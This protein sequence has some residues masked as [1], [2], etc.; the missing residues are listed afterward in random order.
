MKAVI[1]LNGEPHARE[2]DGES[3]YVICCDGAYDWAKDRVKIDENLGDFDSLGYVP[4]PPPRTVYPAEKNATDGEIA[5]DRAIE[6]GAEEIVIYGGGGKREDHFLG[7][8]HLLYAAHKRGVRASMVTNGALIYIGEGEISIDGFYK[9]TLS[10]VPFGGDA[11]IMES[12]GLKYPLHD[13]W[14][15]YGSTRGISN[16]AEGDRA[17]IF[18]EGVVLI[19]VNMEEQ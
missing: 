2:I 11:H 17:S 12:R 6:L 16:I 18:A 4:N 7:N 14:L 15:R 1:L 9:K 13:L 10:I 8:L 3:A 5:L 19:L